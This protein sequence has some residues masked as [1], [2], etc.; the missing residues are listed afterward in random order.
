MLCKYRIFLVLIA[1]NVSSIAWADEPAWPPL[2]W[3]KAAPSPFARVE[4]PAAVVHNKIYL[5]GGFTE[6]LQASNQV[7]V[8]DPASDTWTRKKD[9]PTRLTH[10]NSAGTVTPFGSRAVSRDT[11]PDRSL[12]KCGNTT[13]LR[14]PGPPALLCRNG[15]RGVAWRS[16][17]ANCI[18][19]AA[20][21]PIVTR[22]PAITGVCRSKG[23]RPGS[24]K[25]ICPTRVV[26]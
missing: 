26:T 23:G 5:F 7:D 24:V 25:R 17:D 10:L 14:T 16:W 1:L 21:K 19:S 9:M 6:E 3:Q 8:Y 11:I 18:T 20:T 15:G 2:K 4:S 12:M 13:Y 22:M